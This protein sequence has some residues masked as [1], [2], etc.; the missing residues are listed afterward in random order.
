M[1]FLV[2]VKRNLELLRRAR[3]VSLSVSRAIA[4]ATD[5]DVGHESWDWK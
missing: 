5:S 1:D 3:L 4:H 2:R